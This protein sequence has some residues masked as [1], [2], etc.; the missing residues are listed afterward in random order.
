MDG[1]RREG[2]F[3]L[4]FLEGVHDLQVHALPDIEVFFPHG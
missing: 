3:K 2:E 1:L 4:H